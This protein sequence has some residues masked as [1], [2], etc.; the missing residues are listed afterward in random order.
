MV[1]NGAQEGQDKAN[2]TDLGYPECSGGGDPRTWWIA[3][4]QGLARIGKRPACDLQHGLPL[5]GAPDPI[6][7]RANPATVPWAVD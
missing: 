5:R 1:E 3:F 6:A 7:L 4:M 2:M